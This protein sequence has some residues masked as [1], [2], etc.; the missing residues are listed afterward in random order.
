[1][2][3][4]TTL[5]GNSQTPAVHPVIQPNCDTIDPDSDSTR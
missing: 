3:D 2:G 5:P 1:M 4:F